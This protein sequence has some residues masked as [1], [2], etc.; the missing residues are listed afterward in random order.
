MRDAHAFR[1]F[2]R[3]L[4]IRPLLI[5]QMAFAPGDGPEAFR[6]REAKQKAAAVDTARER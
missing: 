2:S 6:A 1:D 3:D 5:P 4:A